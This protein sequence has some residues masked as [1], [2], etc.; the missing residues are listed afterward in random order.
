MKIT[1]VN[2]GRTINMGNYESVRIDLTADIEEGENWR[3]A[4]ETLKEKMLKE[5]K[6]TK[7][8]GF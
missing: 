2:Y 6:I 4:L 8:Q 1:K 3:E 7:K 5:E